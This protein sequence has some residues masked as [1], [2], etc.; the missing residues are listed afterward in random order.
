MALIA[1]ASLSG[2]GTLR[3]LSGVEQPSRT[4]YG[5]VQQDLHVTDQVFRGEALPPDQNQLQQVIANAFAAAYLA[6]DLPLSAVADTLSLPITM[7]QMS[8]TADVQQSP[9]AGDKQG[10]VKDR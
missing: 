10:L 2:C 4:V 8:G 5:G 9:P 6:V 1:A 7:S 3:N